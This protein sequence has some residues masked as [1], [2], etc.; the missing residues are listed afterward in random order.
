M[1]KV[2]WGG[3]G[4]QLVHFFFPTFIY[5]A[6]LGPLKDFAQSVEKVILVT[7]CMCTATVITP[8]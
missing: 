3:K 2:N 8:K 5:S 7:K 1:T 4:F 6:F